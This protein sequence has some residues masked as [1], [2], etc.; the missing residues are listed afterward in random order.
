MDQLTLVTDEAIDRA[1]KNADQKWFHA[2]LQVGETLAYRFERLTT[3]DIWFE[4]EE[5]H[6]DL[7]T[8]EHRAM[9]AVMRQLKS[10]KVIRPSSLYVQSERL[11]RHGAP[12]RV[13]MSRITKLK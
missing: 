5:S 12:I 4:M 9:G 2:A 3:D 6:P 10:R 7:D 8:H 1:R 11:S 13:W